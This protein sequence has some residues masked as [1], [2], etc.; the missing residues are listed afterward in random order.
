[1]CLAA[2]V[3]HAPGWRRGQHRLRA[4]AF[5][6]SLAAYDAGLHAR[7]RAR[8][9]SHPRR[10]P[11]AQDRAFAPGD[12]NG[13]RA[14]GIVADENARTLPLQEAMK[15]TQIEILIERY[16]QQLE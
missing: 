14:A 16:R 12:R 3:R 13:P 2:H 8:N 7:Q 5:G 10:G 4:T 6:A 9:Q 11:S 15:A 1:T